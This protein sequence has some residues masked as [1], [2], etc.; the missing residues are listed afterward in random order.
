MAAT[1]WSPAP[2]IGKQEW[3]LQDGS[4]VTSPDFEATSSGRRV[5]VVGTQTSVG[6]RQVNDLIAAAID[7]VATERGT[8][9]WMRLFDKTVEE[10][11][12][13]S[14]AGLTGSVFREA[15]NL[16][17][18]DPSQ[19]AYG[20]TTLV[21]DF[22]APGL[23][24]C[25]TVFL[26][27]AQR[28]ASRHDVSTKVVWR[29]TQVTQNNEVP[30]YNTYDG[31]TLNLNN[32]YRYSDEYRAVEE[33]VNKAGGILA[34]H[35]LPARAHSGQFRQAVTDFATRAKALDDLD[36][37]TLPD[38]RDSTKPQFL[39]FKRKASNYNATIHNDIVALVQTG[40]LLEQIKNSYLELVG[41]M[42]RL[43]VVF[44]NKPGDNEFARAA[45]GD[46]TTLRAVIEPCEDVTESHGGTDHNHTVTLDFASG[47][48]IVNC[49][50][51]TGMDE[52][53][54]AWDIAKFK[55]EVVGEVDILLE[56][57]KAYRNPK[58]QARIR[59]IIEQRTTP[60]NL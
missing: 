44:K 55:A 51:T 34:G 27:F 54:E 18:T 2:Y 7:S 5:R 10:D 17:V 8:K 37:I 57:A 12:R 23:P 28:G 22:E 13:A 58:E 19:N 43:G 29:D 46:L 38:M 48:V 20:S 31:S 9:R 21:W 15:V 25:A 35:T 6:S 60:D 59:K 26:T 52:I 42:S 36:E 16:H 14:A 53:A 49:G 40:P 32:L 56:Y 47:S 3:L 33:A 1:T 39:T 30:S 45:A 11:Q 4:I 41:A 24:L 50:H